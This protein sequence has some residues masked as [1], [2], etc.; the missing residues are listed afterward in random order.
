M[1]SNVKREISMQTER[2]I[3]AALTMVIALLAGCAASPAPTPVPD[4]DYCQ[5]VMKPRRK[6]CIFGGVPPA[7]MATEASVLDGV[8]GAFTVYIVRSNWGD[9]TE[10]AELRSPGS[11]V[12][13]T[14]PRT[15][16]RLRLPP[17]PHELSL[18]WKTGA[19]QTIVAGGAGEVQFLQLK[20]WAFWTQRD[21]SLTKIDKATA[22]K[23]TRHS[24][25]VGD[26]GSQ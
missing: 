17:G 7:P 2:L 14:L 9:P 5:T 4:G 19:T 24:K 3:P 26:V 16:A 25:F 21:F 11:P 6:V 10:L 15:F 22:L 23:L 8:A 1:P 18:G 13:Q 20:G 12:I